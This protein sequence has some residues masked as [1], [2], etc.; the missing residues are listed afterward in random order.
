MRP[1]ITERDRYNAAGAAMAS[2]NAQRAIRTPRLS[3]TGYRT[4][5][6]QMS[7]R[8]NQTLEHLTETALSNPQLTAAQRT[9]LKAITL[10]LGVGL[11]QGRFQTAHSQK[12]YSLLSDLAYPNS[13][14]GGSEFRGAFAHLQRAAQMLQDPEYR[15]AKLYVD[16]GPQNTPVMANGAH[17]D[18][19]ADM[20]AVWKGA[21]NGAPPM[22]IESVKAQP[23][24][25]QKKV[26]QAITLEADA[27]Q[28]GRQTSWRSAE[29]SR[30][31]GFR[32]MGDGGIGRLI[33]QPGAIDVLEGAVGG[34]DVRGISITDR[35]YTPNE[36]R[37]LAEGA[38][39]AL[40]EHVA[41]GGDRAEYAK[42]KLSTAADMR[43][44]LGIDVGEKVAPVRSP[45][46]PASAVNGAVAAGGITVAIAASDGRI[47]RQEGV[48]IAK[49]T[50]MGAGTAA[51]QTAGEAGLARVVASRAPALE[52]AAS[53]SVARTAVSRIGGSTAVGAVITAGLS[54]YENRDGLSHGDSHVI[55]NVAADTTVG[56]GSM[57]AGAAAGAAIGSVVPVAGTAVGAAVG[58]GV[59]LLANNS[60]LRDAISN[61]VSS[62]VDKIKSWF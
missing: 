59:S 31:V 21:G 20:L 27:N 2:A 9:E 61:G 22:R 35:S 46:T 60:G 58:A 29:G 39:N 25:I 50:V 28:I 53:S 54:A 5:Y 18:L 8:P 19:D 45:V 44:N 32:T 41:A 7:S 47:D 3:Q 26:D 30:S 17:P 6:D 16:P 11:H 42:E 15:G 33:S 10:E 4:D 49:S 56:A 51:A 62:A 52:A 12:F 38:S 14:S 55:G 48:A 40:D 1:G 34:P 36:L 57:L 43:R 13:R 23:S 37:R 24:T